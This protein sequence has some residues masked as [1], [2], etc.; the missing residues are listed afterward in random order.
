L[1]NHNSVFCITNHADCDLLH[2]KYDY[3]DVCYYWKQGRCRFD[4]ECRNRHD[5]LCRK[6]NCDCSSWHIPNKKLQ[7]KIIKNETDKKVWRLIKF[8][9]NF[10]A[11][12]CQSKIKKPDVDKLRKEIII[13]WLQ[14]IWHI[15]EIKSCD[16]LQK[17]TWVCDCITISTAKNISG[18]WK[19][20]RDLFFDGEKWKELVAKL[21]K[22]YCYNVPG[23]FLISND[24]Q[25]EWFPGQKR[26]AE[27]DFKLLSDEFKQRLKRGIDEVLPN[28]RGEK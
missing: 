23:V 6:Q 14:I 20:K 27:I 12:F 1:N 8:I 18:I 28:F 3:H 9:R 19:I 7:G 10:T 26:P 25:T 24:Y 21:T 22:N 13:L 16:T 11:H 15:G 5:S 17:Q 4:S 2:A